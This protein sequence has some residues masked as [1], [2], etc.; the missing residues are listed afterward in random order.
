MRK[1][2]IKVIMT[3]ED[4]TDVSRDGCAKNDLDEMISIVQDRMLERAKNGKTDCT[5]YFKVSDDQAKELIQFFA[6]V[7]FEAS[8]VPN[9]I[10]S[11]KT[12]KFKWNRKEA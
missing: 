12:F 9:V 1:E 6:N 7:G 5:L 10:G 3:A 4:M 11:A 8:Y 2:D